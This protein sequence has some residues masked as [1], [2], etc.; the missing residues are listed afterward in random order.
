MQSLIHRCYFFDNSLLNWSKIIACLASVNFNRIL[1]ENILQIKSIVRKCFIGNVL[2]TFRIS[3]ICSS[4]THNAISNFNYI[5]QDRANKLSVHIFFVELLYDALL[6][7]Y[8]S[9]DFIK[10]DIYNYGN[11]V[12]ELITTLV[13]GSSLVDKKVLILLETLFKYIKA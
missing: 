7:P 11:V 2:L 5:E 4:H 12:R 1:F 13:A 10:K 8:N 3:K 9:Y 6:S